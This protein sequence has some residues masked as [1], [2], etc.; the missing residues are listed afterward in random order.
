MPTPPRP[1]HRDLRLVGLVALGGA[2]GSVLRYAVALALPVHDGGWPL[3]TLTVN[4]VGAFAL[5]WLLEGLAGRGRET[6]RGRRLRLFAGTGLLGGFTTYSSL[7]LETERLLAAGDVALALAYLS[8]TL[9]VGSLAAAAG[10]AV[11]LRTP[12]GVVR[13]LLREQAR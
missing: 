10:V 7:A 4:V 6:L 8:V 9:V 5:G 2:I 1:A 11:G 12:A 3:A 13:L